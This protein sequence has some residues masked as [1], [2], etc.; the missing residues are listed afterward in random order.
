MDRHALIEEMYRENR[1]PGVER[2]DETTSQLA[3]MSAVTSLNV[4]MFLM[5]FKLEC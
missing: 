3:K 2:L 5:T 1:M 4:M